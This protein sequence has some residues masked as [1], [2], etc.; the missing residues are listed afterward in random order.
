M[1]LSSSEIAAMNG[2]F[3]QQSMMSQQYSSMIGQGGNVYGAGSGMSGD[4][5]M[6]SAMN[7][8]SAVGAPLMSG[9]MGLLGLDPMSLGLKA[10]MGAFGAGAGF[11]GAAMA[12]AAVA[13]PLMAAGAGIHYAGSQMFTGAQ[14]QQ[15]MNNVLRQSFN[16]RNQSGGQGFDRSQMS[17]IGGMM[18]EMGSQ[19]GPGGEVASVSE[20][21]Q[22]AGKMG[23]MGFAQGVRD[24]KEFGTRFK[25]MVKTLKEMA[26][27]LGTTMEGAMEFAQSAK[28][29]GVFG[30]NRIAGFTS[31]ARGATVSGG[32]AMS[33]VT[34]AAS[35]GSQ[36]A[37]SIGGLG[38]Q[39]A[40]AG[41]R[42][43]GQIGTAQQMG[44]INEEDIYNSTGLGGAEG[45]QAFAA[46]QMQ[47]AGS[48][49]QSGKGRR[50]LASLADKNGSLDESRVDQLLSGGMGIAE[51]MSADKQQLGKVGRANFIR[52]EGR[53]RGA[54]M[55]RLGAFLPAMQLQQWAS[56]KGIDINNMDDR[57]MLFAQRQLGM[58][59]DE[60]DTAMKMA[61]N[62]P[63]IIEQQRRSGQDDQ[64]FQ[65]LAQG[66]KQRGVEGI[67]GRFDQARE[68]VNSK[69]QKIGADIFNQGAEDID[70][71]FN[72]LT[73]SYVETF[74]KDA[75]AAYRSLG[76][77]SASR[78]F[79]MGASGN[80]SSTF[81]SFGGKSGIGGGGASS[82]FS[83][84]NRG[85]NVDAAGAVS[86]KGLS[87]GGLLTGAYA[88]QLGGFLGQG[89]SD[90]S[91]LRDA[92]FDMR[93][94]HDDASAQAKL[95][96]IRSMR[97]AAATGFNAEDVKL[98]AGSGEW[99]RNAYLSKEMNGLSGEA[100]MNALGSA[101]NKNGDANM[102]AAW[103]AAKTPEERAALIANLERGA[104]IKGAGSTA[105]QLNLPGLKGIESGTYASEAERNRAYAGALSVGTSAST[106]EQAIAAGLR[107]TGAALSNALLGPLGG[108]ATSGLGSGF[109]GG[110]ASRLSGREEKQQAAGG[111]LGSAGGRDATLAL[112]GNDSGTAKDMVAKLQSEVLSDPKAPVNDAKLA[113]IDAASY[114]EAARANGGPLSPADE[115][116]WEQRTG[117]NAATAKKTLGGMIDVMKDAQNANVAHEA[118]RARDQAMNTKTELAASG[119]YDATTGGLSSAK[120]AELDKMDKTGHMR[121]IAEAAVGKVNIEASLGGTRY[122]TEEDRQKFGQMAGND[123][124]IGLLTEGMSV[125][126]QRALAGKL[127]PLGG[128][129]GMHA[130][131]QDRLEKGTR[132]RGGQGKA[133]ADILGVS[134]SPDELAA[135]GK[136]GDPTELLAR[137]G[138]TDKA[139]IAEAKNAKGA[140][141]LATAIQHG[142]E[143]QS[144][145]DKKKSD[146]MADDESKNPL[147]AA[148]KKNSDKTN[149]LLESLVKLTVG[150]NDILAKLGQD[151]PEHFGP[152]K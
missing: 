11:G 114:A 68:V 128:G 21:T 20:L 117:K 33:E 43:I 92:G 9:A 127:G 30:M 64:Y 37:R 134:A 71:F 50:M 38:R 97:D 34:G 121:A 42:T 27:D 137:A 118:R 90:I 12:G 98:G 122:T 133:L 150:G 148:I 96:S 93:G 88:Q 85:V 24:V 112:L 55:E 120:A 18:R 54:A 106:G 72:K 51:T 81:S 7:R 78:A 140:G 3:M 108:L 62:M 63:Q 73:G 99:I 49:L 29:S 82:M 14:Q 111:F 139:I 109:M 86:G 61:N 101:I 60:M 2:G 144:Y 13:A 100:R 69:L 79:G 146:S 5:F 22:I 59:R 16:F 80:V 45:R 110:L 10:G 31:A 17:S 19:F 39:G 58:G 83:Q 41:I 91:K 23:Q 40:M 77:T 141:A 136:G 131:I 25:E 129:V 66:R 57:S 89:Q 130:S 147:Q 102:K 126:D 28:G 149:T 135:L 124:S 119:L 115:K 36:I 84:M 104:G 142:M 123:A 138:I 46:S 4:A 152:K 8:G 151:D 94:V 75:D 76:S 67:K 56:S 87:T 107:A 113:M 32:L 35:I 116:T 65:Q 132:R 103:A 95:L 26:K 53:L 15:T 143:T 74:S 70:A 6:G 44:V 1:P 105:E 47:R 145:Q 125:K 48:F 52:N